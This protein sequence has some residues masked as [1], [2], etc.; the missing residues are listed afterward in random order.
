MI[1]RMTSV[2]IVPMLLAVVSALQ[3]SAG[4]M[5]WDHF[6]NVTD[7][8]PGALLLILLDVD[9][10]G[11]KEIFLAPTTTCGNGGCAW[12]V[13]S[14]SSTPN[15]VRYLGQAGFSPG[16]FRLTPGTHALTSCWHMS[17]ADCELGEHR[18]ENGRM[19]FRKLGTCRSADT[20]CDT[21]LKRI[22]AWQAEHDV[23]VLSAEV[24]ETIDLD[25]LKWLRRQAPG[26]ATASD[27]PDFKNLV[28]VKIGR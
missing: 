21:E 20:S 2:L 5:F 23:P 11:R 13:Y 19:S 6:V 15:R 24:N 3:P 26:A 25:S 22:A 12:A 14:P 16:G 9:G 18:I 17:A 4:E 10:D 27:L 28:V 7:V 8:G 1:S